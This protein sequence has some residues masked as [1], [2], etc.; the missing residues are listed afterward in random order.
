MGNALFD[1]NFIFFNILPYSP[2]R[3]EELAADAVTGITARTAE[4]NIITVRAV[5]IILF[6]FIFFLLL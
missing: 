4:N 5:D 2:G 1:R 3:E 6:V